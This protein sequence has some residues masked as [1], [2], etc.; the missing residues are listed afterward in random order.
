MKKVL[1]TGGTG[2]VGKELSRFLK[3]KGYEL[4]ILSRQPTNDSDIQHYKWDIDKKEIDTKAFEGTKYIIHL[5]GE[6]IGSKRW[7]KKRKKQILESR[8]KSTELLYDTIKSNNYPIEAFVSASAVGIYPTLKD[9]EDY[10]IEDDM[11][12]NSFTADV[13]KAWE[14][15]VNKIKKLGIRTVKIRT[16]VV[17]HPQ[18]AIL[19]STMNSA[20]FNIL[21]VLG[22]GKQY[23]PW[24]HIYDLCN[25]Y[26]TALENE[27][28][29]DPFNAVAPDYITNFDYIK[30]IK[31]VRKKG[32]IIKVPSFFI[33]SLFGER[34][35]IILQGTKVHSKLHENID[36]EFKYPTINEAV[37]DMIG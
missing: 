24:I 21:P 26:Y 28:F 20:R 35:E 5:A 15:E 32:A 30:T 12:G 4:A 18:S 17:L 33:K 27:N 34:S 9:G 13:C 36:F 7:T 3:N 31:N 16:G 10:Y 1:I 8:V 6:N 37:E 25:I 14:N 22:K 11:Y 23:L 2:L 19:K 29:N